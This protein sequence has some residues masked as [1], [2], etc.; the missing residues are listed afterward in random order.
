MT[1]VLWNS[2][3]EKALPLPAFV[4]D[5]RRNLAGRRRT[6]R[7]VYFPEGPCAEPAESSQSDPNEHNSIGPV[8]VPLA[9]IRPFGE[10]A[11]DQIEVSLLT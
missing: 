6:R 7:F 3:N 8:P 1:P 10:N 5:I 11:I 2:A 4:C 9:S